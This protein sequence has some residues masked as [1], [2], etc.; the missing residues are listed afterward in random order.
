MVTCTPTYQLPVVEGS[1]RPCDI[2]DW[3]CDFAAA[4]ESQLDRLDAVVARTATSRPLFKVAATIPITYTSFPAAFNT[5]F[6]TVFADTNNMFNSDAPDTI[7]INTAGIYCFTAFGWGVQTGPGGADIG[8][9]GF[10]FRTIP[11]ATG[12]ITSISTDQRTFTASAQNT[13]LASSTTWAL[14]AGDQ[15][16]LGQNTGSSSVGTLTINEVQFGGVWLGDLS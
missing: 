8:T 13:Y 16:F 15:V 12:G 7:V 2:D 9:L 14:N 3:S 10:L 5:S 11:I 4:V 1:D 6:D